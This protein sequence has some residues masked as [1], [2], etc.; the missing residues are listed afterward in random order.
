VIGVEKIYPARERV[1]GSVL[2]ERARDLGD[3]TFLR[4]DGRTLSYAQ[5]DETADRVAR[6]FA[7]RGVDKEDKVCIMLPNC[8]EFL[9]C[10]FGLARLGTVEV[11]INTAYKGQFLRYVI[12]DSEAEVLVIHEQWL[13]RLEAVADELPRL[14]RVIVHAPSSGIGLPERI[15]DAAVEPYKRLLESEARRSEVEVRHSDTLAIMYTSGTT[16]RSKG[17]MV[18]NCHALTFAYDWIKACAY[19]TRDVLYTPLP[20]FHSIA[21]TLGVFPVLL[22]GSE[23][24]IVERF[25][26]S[27]FWDD[28]RRFE[29]TVSHG[30][31]GMVP[32]LLNQ[33]PTERDKDHRLK[34]FYI[35]PSVAND[36][37]EERFGAKVVEVYGATETGI[38]TAAPYGENRAG[39][40]GMENSDSFEVRVFDDD[41]NEV[42]VGEV[43]EIV[44]RPRV[45]F[46]MMSGYYNMPEATVTSCRNLWFHTG[47]YGRKDEDGYFFFVD[48]KKDAIRR[49]GENISSFEVERAVNSHLAVLESAAIAVPSE[50]NEDEVKVCVVLKRGQTLGARE[51]VEYLNEE[52]PY[53][54]VPRYVEFVDVLPKTPNEKVEK[55]KLRQQGD[56]GITSGTWDREEHGVRITR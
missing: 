26:A 3:K 39:S 16:G 47:D 46:A 13:D 35:G 49:R 34:T 38:V 41:D 6:S 25:S 51:L 54:M 48:R 10:T 56:A 44:V 17:V 42:G 8:P 52:L 7:E 23:I 53:F 1:V 50:L 28:V 21:H 14:R 4:F 43:G 30:I 5:V 18:S 24:A 11:P 55:Y 33:E 29:A 20:L 19:E 32:I 45:P 40:C 36:A 27:Q 2:A 9:F 12:E 15:G 37:F 31:F 22:T